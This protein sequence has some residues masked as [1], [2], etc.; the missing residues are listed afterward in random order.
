MEKALRVAKPGEVLSLTETQRRALLT[1]ETPGQNL[2]PTENPWTLSPAETL[3]Q[4]RLKGLHPLRGVG[5][6]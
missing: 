3:G 2:S 6:P 1:T 4:P 5:S